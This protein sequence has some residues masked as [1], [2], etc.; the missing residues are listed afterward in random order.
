MLRGYARSSP[1][2]C[3]IRLNQ[4]TRA[5]VLE[6]AGIT[7]PR[8]I[9][10]VYTARARSVAAVR[11]LR[12]AYSDVQIYARAL[13]SLHAAELKAAGAST[14]IT[15]NTE[16][17]T[18]MGSQLLFDLGANANGVRAQSCPGIVGSRSGC[19]DLPRS[20]CGRIDPSVDEICPFF[21]DK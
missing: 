2:K 18:E 4:V 12:E 13:D 1:G 14:V 9:A 15:A 6:A 10:V 16:V 11:S 8:A 20:G 17:A 21:D 7:E 19:T 5:Q 3:T